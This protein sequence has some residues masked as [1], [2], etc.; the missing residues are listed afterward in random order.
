MKA[1]LPFWPAA[2]RQDQA[3]A[4]CGLSVATFVAICPVNLMTRPYWVRLRE[5][6]HGVAQSQHLVGS[7]RMSRLPYILHRVAICL[8][9]PKQIE[10]ACQG[11][12][13]RVE[14]RYLGGVL[15]DEVLVEKDSRAC[16]GLP[17]FVAVVLGLRR[18][19]PCST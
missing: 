18:A 10:V 9:E 14:F 13:I 12:Q 11:L 19:R 3:A 17:L 5:I 16:R 6:R 8:F 2:L 1:D 15:G 7:E 4:Y